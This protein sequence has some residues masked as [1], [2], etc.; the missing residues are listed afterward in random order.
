MFAINGY[1][2]NLLWF[3]CQSLKM[4]WV[5]KGLY[6]ICSV[7][8]NVPKVLQKSKHEKGRDTFNHL[9][10]INTNG[11]GT[12]IWQNLV[13]WNNNKMNRLLGQLTWH[14]NKCFTV[15]TNRP[16]RMSMT[17]STF[18]LGHEDIFVALQNLH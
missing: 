5:G 14:C 3:A 4:S 17:Q 9:T 6:C 11:K 1:R 7:K 18:S 15:T 10:L 16:D 2:L 12:K 8:A 13:H